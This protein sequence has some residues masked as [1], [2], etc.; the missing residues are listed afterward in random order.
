MVQIERIRFDETGPGHCGVAVSQRNNRPHIHV[1]EIAEND[2]EALN[3]RFAEGFQAIRDQ[4]CPGTPLSDIDWEYTNGICHSDI[5]FEEQNG[6]LTRIHLHGNTLGGSA[7]KSPLQRYQD[8]LNSPNGFEHEMTSGHNFM[9][10]PET[11]IFPIRLGGEDQD[12]IIYYTS[13]N[14]NG[15]TPVLVDAAKF[16]QAWHQQEE[17][18]LKP[19]SP[20]PNKAIGFLRSLFA[21]AAENIP[22]REGRMHD[23]ALFQSTPEKSR[24]EIWKNTCPQHPIQAAFISFNADQPDAA[25]AFINGRHRTFNAA[26][27]AAPYVVIDVGG[28]VEAFRK[29]FEWTPP[30]PAAQLQ[31]TVQPFTQP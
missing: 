25:I 11:D 18:L 27:L 2:G 19:A 16:V 3:A 13:N 10:G 23:F 17:R 24:Q 6:T 22:D 9:R 5:T 31:R 20:P 30:A 15:M 12:R 26:N 21:D 29:K 1:F 14:Y 28:D 8:A 4:C 7:F